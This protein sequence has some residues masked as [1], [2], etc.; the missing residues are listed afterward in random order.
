ML[1]MQ[2]PEQ[3]GALVCLGAGSFLCIGLVVEFALGLAP[4]PLCM[5]QRIWFALAGIVTIIGLTHNPRWGI[6]PLLSALCAMIG[7]AFCDSPAMVTKSAT[8]SGTE[9]RARPGLHD[10]RLPLGRALNRNDIGD[11]RL[12]RCLRRDP[13][14]EHRRMGLVGFHHYFCWQCYAVTSGASLGRSRRTASA[15]ASAC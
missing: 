5:M 9:L 8:R 11:R 3:W 1:N 4:C 7:G 13:I 2:K 15:L 12:C 6:Y 10:R 14:D